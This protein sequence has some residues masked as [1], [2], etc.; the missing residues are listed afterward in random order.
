MIEQAY[1]VY[2]VIG[3][4]TAG[5]LLTLFRSKVR[6]TMTIV[7]MMIIGVLGQ[8]AMI[9]PSAVTFTDPMFIAVASASF[10]EGGVLVSLV[11]FVHE[12]YGTENFGI[13][14]GTM[15]SFGAAGLFAIDEIFFPNIFEWYAEENAKGVK[16]FKSY[17][18]WNQ[19]LF[20]CIAGAY[21]ICMI[22]ALI[23][24]IS[25]VHREVKDSNKLVMV[26][27]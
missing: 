20:G 7:F 3:A 21:F 6:P 10:S 11:S 14:F 17:G 5:T 4:T 8:L 12:E 2:E 25:V 13:I 24:H 22:L 26:N 27:F 16:Y 1:N 9:W 19:F 15:V 23:S 18:K